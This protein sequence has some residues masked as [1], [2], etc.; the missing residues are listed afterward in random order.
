MPDAAPRGSRPGPVSSTAGVV[1]TSSGT[2]IQ[3]SPDSD[4]TRAGSGHATPNRTPPFTSAPAT[5]H[6][7]PVRTIARAH[8]AVDGVI[9]RTIVPSGAARG[10]TAH[11][12]RVDSVIQRSGAVT[13]SSGLVPGQPATLMLARHT[14]GP[15]DPSLPGD[16]Q[17]GR[18]ETWGG[19]VGQ[20]GILAALQREGES[21]AASPAAGSQP[22][23]PGGS[24]DP[25]PTTSGTTP[26]A[27][28]EQAARLLRMEEELRRMNRMY[29]ML[30]N[31]VK[32]RSERTGQIAANLR[33]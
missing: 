14:A 33:G 30:S 29:E 2:T 23:P 7:F 4:A 26:E 11:P 21:P 15:S 13:G 18:S 12:L 20:P 17:G 19:S 28:A 9:S 22:T 16:A 8:S 31:I 1:P 5:D 3:R 25:A 27:P 32:Y 24:P 6:A 10:A